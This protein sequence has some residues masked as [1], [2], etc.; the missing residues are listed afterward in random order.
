VLVKSVDPVVIFTNLNYLHAF[1]RD[2][3]LPSRTPPV[4]VVDVSMGYGLGLNDT[5]AISL[6][7]SGLFSRATTVGGGSTRPSVFSARFALTTW[8]AEGLYL[9]P[10]ISF[11]LSGPGESFALGVTMPYAF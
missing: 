10:S 9:E 8:L 7:V 4:D 2:A 11:G 6:A 3:T 1:E 5:V